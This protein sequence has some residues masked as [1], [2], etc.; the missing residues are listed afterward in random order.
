MVRLVI[1]SLATVS[2][3]IAAGCGD[4]S[5]PRP[6][7]DAADAFL[8][9]Y[10]TSDG[11]ILRH[12]QGGDVVSEGQ[13]YGMLIAEVAHRPDTVRAVWSWTHAH[14]T[15]PDGLLISHANASGGVIDP[16]SAADADT[17]AAYALLR[18]AGSGEDELHDA[19]RAVAAAVL[20]HESTTLG[21]APV[22]L[23]GPWAKQMSPPVVNPSYWMPA[24]FAALGRRT[25]DERWQQAASTAVQLL[26]ESTGNGRSLP[27]DWGRL[28]NGRLAPMGDPA[29]SVSV[30]YGL[31]AARL[32]VWLATACDAHA[33]RLAAHWWNSTLSGDDRASKLALSTT[34][35]TINGE[36][37]PLPLMAGA[38]AARVAGK[39]AASRELRVRAA[40]QSRTTPTYYGDAWLAL[41]GALLD[42][43]LDPCQEAGDG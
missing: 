41:G 30:Q 9:R 43:T 39:D 21:G 6:G 1:A 8:A 13:A 11:R 10:V 27:T 42:R 18:Y 29:G 17:L 5:P 19:G 15:R 7:S 31:D 37:N 25:G 14:L 26:A 16:Q 20:D 34:G 32:P 40:Q 2:A 24:I 22:V 3:L 38:A 4:T 35:S 28:S 33:R 12:D 23:A 36:T